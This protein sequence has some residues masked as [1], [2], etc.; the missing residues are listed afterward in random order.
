MVPYTRGRERSRSP[1]AVVA[2][3]DALVR[4][5]GVREV[6]LLGQNVNSYKSGDQRFRHLVE[7]ILFETSVERLRFTSPHPH[8]FPE[9]LLDLMAR[10]E[11][12]CSQI[13]LPLQSGATSTLA[14]SAMRA[15]RFDM[16]FM[17]HYSER[18]QTYAHKRM[19]DDV[20]HETKLARLQQLI[21]LQTE[22]ARE[23]NTALIGREYDV[24]V[25]GRSKRSAVELMGRN[26]AGKAVIFPAPTPAFSLAG[27]SELSAGSASVLAETD[28]PTLDPTRFVGQTLRVRVTEST[29]ATLRG[30]LVG[31]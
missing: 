13:H 29:P 20:P 28:R 9:D 16:A 4:E 17:F 11:R 3:I 10:E 6:T 18:Q 5:D 27:G 12:F 23:K 15:V 26:A 21:E 14:R 25:E 7:Q 30:E 31:A 19:P 8:D 2:E 22:I 1:E 24:L